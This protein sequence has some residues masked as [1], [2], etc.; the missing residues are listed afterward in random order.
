MLKGPRRSPMRDVMRRSLIV[1]VI[2]LLTAAAPAH[3]ATTKA[4]WVKSEQRTVRLDQNAALDVVLSPL[5]GKKAA[6]KRVIS[7]IRPH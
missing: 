1:T 2:A 5:P 3:A 4:H 7:K 6:F